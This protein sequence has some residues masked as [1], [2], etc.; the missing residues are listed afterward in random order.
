MKLKIYQVDAFAGR[1]FTGNPAAVCPL[2]HWLPD[3]I[4]QNIAMENNLAETAF[5]VKKDG[6]FQIRWFT[7]TVEVDLCGHAT[8]ASAFVLFKY[9]NHPENSIRFISPR[10]GD[11]SVRRMGDLLILNF[12]RDY[13]VPVECTDEIKTCFNTAPNLA[14][15]GKTD[16]LFVFDS[17]D[18]I[19]NLVPFLEKI[20]KLEGRGV[21]VTA[22][23]NE[24]DFVARFFAPQSGINEDPVTGSAYTTLIPYWYHQL[25][26][27]EMT[28]K[29]LSM[30]TGFVH[31]KYLDERVEIGGEAC[32][33]MIGEIFL[34]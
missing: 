7:P 4:L 34:D 24:Q 33:Y 23:G 10:S 8:L 20:S 28:A 12:P 6:H 14:F 9:D 13:F 15:K 11:L 18:K 2:D 16:Y 19:A 3:E 26:K 5:Y 22:K 1:V 17:E 32:L 21:I 30:R 29:Q 31:C 25:G 27:A